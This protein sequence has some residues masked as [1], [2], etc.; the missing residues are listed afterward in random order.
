MANAD[1]NNISP[2]D[3]MG[4]GSPFHQLTVLNAILFSVAIRILVEAYR[5]RLMA[6][7][8]FGLVIHEFDPYFNFRATEVSV[9][10][11]L[12]NIIYCLVISDE[13]LSLDEIFFFEPLY[14]FVSIE[15]NE[16]TLI[17]ICFI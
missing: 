15:C 11:L 8:D 6:I 10:F 14:I 2:K 17:E 5:I 1:R 7:R 12:T 16:R 13:C 9:P 3:Q 4:T